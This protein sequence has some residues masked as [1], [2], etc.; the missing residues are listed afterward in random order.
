M[1]V[2]CVVIQQIQRDVVLT[3]RYTYRL[4]LEVSFF[5][6]MWNGLVYTLQTVKTTLPPL[7]QGPI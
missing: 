3:L 5:L 1:T 7:F 6:A 2:M 4:V